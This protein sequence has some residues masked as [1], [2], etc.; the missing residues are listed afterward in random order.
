MPGCF[1]GVNFTGFQRT[2]GSF[3][4][5]RSAQTRAPSSHGAPYQTNGFSVPPATERMVPSSAPRPGYAT[6]AASDRMLGDGLIHGSPVSSKYI[7]LFHPSIF[8]T[9]SLQPILN[10]ELYSRAS[11]PSVRPWRVGS[12]K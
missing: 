7:D 6:A 12:P 2:P 4:D 9:S 10:S 11:S 1:A 3:R 8:T 5:S